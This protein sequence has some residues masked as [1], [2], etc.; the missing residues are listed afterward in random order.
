MENVI[1]TVE[2]D[3]DSRL[4]AH[5]RQN[6]VEDGGQWDMLANLVLKYGRKTIAL[7]KISSKM[8]EIDYEI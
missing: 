2:E 1:D 5:I 4:F 3:V 8:R 7:K 6:P